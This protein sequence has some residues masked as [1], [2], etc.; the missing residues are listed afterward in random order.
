MFSTFMTFVFST[1]MIMTV[2]NVPNVYIYIYIDKGT[3]KSQ[4]EPQQVC[5]PQLL[6]D[7]IR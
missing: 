5:F 4:I 1:F 6:M 3:L 7:K 2:R